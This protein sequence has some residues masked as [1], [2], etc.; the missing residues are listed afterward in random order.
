M[1][2]VDLKDQRL[3]LNNIVRKEQ[4]NSTTVY[5]YTVNQTIDNSYAPYL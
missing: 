3:R 4:K 5:T 1:G 2:S